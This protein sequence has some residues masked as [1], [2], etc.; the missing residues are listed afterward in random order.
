VTT[1]PESSGA[2]I[3]FALH[4]PDLDGT[5]DADMVVNELV[6]IINEERERNG[7]RQRPEE[8]AVINLFPAPQFIT[9]Q[10]IQEMIRYFTSITQEDSDA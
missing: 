5:E 9:G 1:T 3:L 8:K 2:T 10:Q 7:G 6:A 4:I